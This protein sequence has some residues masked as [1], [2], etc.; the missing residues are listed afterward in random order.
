MERH[1][2]ESY[3]GFAV[4]ARKILLGNT[5]AEAGL[6]KIKLILICGTSQKNSIK[7]A[8]SIS[9][10]TQAPMVFC[11]NKTLSEITGSNVKIAAITDKSLAKAII[12]NC[13]DLY[14][15]V[16]APK[17]QKLYD[18]YV[19]E[20]ELNGDDSIGEEVKIIYNKSKR[21]NFNKHKSIHGNLNN[22]NYKVKNF[23]K[24]KI[25][26]KDGSN[27][28]EH[29]NTKTAFN[30]NQNRNNFKNYGLKKNFGNKNDAEKNDVKKNKYTHF[31]KNKISK[32]ADRSDINKTEKTFKNTKKFDGSLKKHNSVDKSFKFKKKYENRS[33][34]TDNNI[35]AKKDK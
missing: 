26:L 12:E 32:N 11:R 4:K 15:Y 34:T 5:A 21:D 7:K 8:N 14:Y 9:V 33:Q 2:V 18:E 6:K 19:Y 17:P 22:K 20:S 31:N 23:S 24:A 16:P 29:K 25:E 28:I 27:I 1:K 30:K 3:I 13:D 35:S 10:K